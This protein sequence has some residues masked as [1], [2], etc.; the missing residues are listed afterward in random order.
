MKRA[1]HTL[2]GASSNPDHPHAATVLENMAKCYRKMGKED[3]A[4]RLE[5]IS[6]EG[7]A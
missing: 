6:K 3:E 2:G 4:K 7:G 1:A 5:S